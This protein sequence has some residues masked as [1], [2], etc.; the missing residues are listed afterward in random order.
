MPL[1]LDARLR[2]GDDPASANVLG[3]LLQER[4][5]TGR[6]FNNGLLRFHNAASG[7]AAVQAVAPRLGMDSADVTPVAFDWLGRQLVAVDRDGESLALLVDGARESVDELC[8]VPQLFSLLSHEE[9]DEVFAGTAFT[10]W[11][12]SNE[13]DALPFSDCVA[14]IT[15]LNRGGEDSLANTRQEAVADYWQ[16]LNTAA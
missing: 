5:L 7:Q 14:F 6:S 2:A 15:P 9:V 12:A 3:T 10:M 13:V 1:H 11:R 4:G 8:T 16:R